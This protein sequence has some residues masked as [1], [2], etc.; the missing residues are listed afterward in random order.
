MLAAMGGICAMG[1]GEQPEGAE[2]YGRMGNGETCN[3]AK[4]AKSIKMV[5]LGKP[6]GRE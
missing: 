2:I 1:N 3:F 4:M 6:V 5:K